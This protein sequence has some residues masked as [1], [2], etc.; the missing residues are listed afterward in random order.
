MRSTGTY[1]SRPFFL[2]IPCL[3]VMFPS[4]PVSAG[5]PG[6]SSHR[7][8]SHPF[9]QLYQSLVDSYVR[10]GLP[11]LVLLIKTPEEGTWIGTGGYARLEDRTPVRP[12]HLFH[13]ASMAKFYTA[14]AVLLLKDQGFIELDALM[15]QYVSDT[16][17]GR[18]ANG[19]AV[20]L[21]HLLSHRSGFPQ[22]EG[23]AQEWNDRRHNRTWQDQLESTYDREAVFS[24]GAAFDYNNVNYILLAVIMD[25]LTGDHADFFRTG[26]FQPMGLVN[27]YYKDII[28][29][30]GVVDI[31]WD[32]YANGY[33]ENISF[34]IHDL[35]Y[36]RDYGSGGIIAP[37]SEYAGF[38]EEVLSGGILSEE[39]L[40]EMTTPTYA[41]FYCLGCDSPQS[42]ADELY[43]RAYGTRGSGKMGLSHMYYFPDA[44][45]TIGYAT[46]FSSD[47][48]TPPLEA[49]TR[50]WDEVT[51]T[52]FF[53]RGSSA[54]ESQPENT[55]TKLSR[56]WKKQP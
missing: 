8:D 2:L 13:S 30:P 36:H 11:G 53:L 21:R 39:S 44:G 23:N 9:H 32:R 42:P 10:K 29:P 43:G 40:V 16:I 6:L 33:L 19:H 7:N 4:A 14:T 38:I 1:R 49:F 51:H 22:P 56:I 47:G 41:D 31:Y 55:K 50:I 26:L 27:T 28:R 37:I 20:T 3:L 18:L 54:P 45:V 48:V 5:N 15:D 46:N 17:C 12:D 52:V 34:W 35:V 25:Q 24:P